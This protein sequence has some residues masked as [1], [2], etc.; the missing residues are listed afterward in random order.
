MGDELDGAIE[1]A[2]ETLTILLE[3]VWEEESDVELVDKTAGDIALQTILM[4]AAAT[5]EEKDK[6]YRNIQHL[7]ATVT[8][9]AASRYVLTPGGKGLAV[10]IIAVR[11]ALTMLLTAA[12]AESRD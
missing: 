10:F 3:G 7:M 5:T 12:L 11:T 1:L 2:K 8:S 6:H 9:I 4:A